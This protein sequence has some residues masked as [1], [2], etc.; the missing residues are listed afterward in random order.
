MGAN[1]LLEAQEKITSDL[2]EA[3]EEQALQGSPV[4]TNIN[5]FEMGVIPVEGTTNDQLLRRKAIARNKAGVIMLQGEP[6]FSS[7]DQILI[8]ELIF[9]IKQNDL[10]A[11]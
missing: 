11:D 2:L 3:T 7:N 10:K 5:G 6:S 1:N 4:V 9:Y 8:D